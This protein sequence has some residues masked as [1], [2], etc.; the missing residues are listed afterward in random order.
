MTPDDIRAAF[1]DEL[2]RIAPDI[3]PEDIGDTDHIQEDLEL[4]IHGCTEP[5]HG[6][7]P[8]F[9]FGHH[10]IR[11]SADFDPI[12]GRHVHRWKARVN[13]PRMCRFFIERGSIAPLRRECNSC[14]IAAPSS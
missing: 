8:T 2:T 7:A 3:A 9:G 4:D 12:A 10:G 13:R 14:L 11:V 6:T 1:I 5:G